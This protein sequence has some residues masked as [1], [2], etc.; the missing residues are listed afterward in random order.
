MPDADQ[1]PEPMLAD[2]RP[3]NPRATGE[4]RTSLQARF[5]A[6]TLCSTFAILV[7]FFAYLEVSQYRAAGGEIDDRIGRMLES[8]SL[9]LA[10]ATTAGDAERML[11]LLAPVLGDPDV[12]SIAVDLADGTR[13]AAHGVPLGEISPDLV[14]RHPIINVVGGHPVRVGWVVAAVSHHRI[15]RELRD[16]LFDH[17]V[18]ALLIF[19]AIVIGIQ[20][21]LQPT[22][23]RPMRRLL[24]AI[25]GWE[26][27]ATPTPVAATRNDEFGRL[28]RAFNEMQRRQLVYQQDLRVARDTAEAADR[29]KTAFLAIMSHELRTPLNAI[30]GFSELLKTIANTGGAARGDYLDAIIDSGHKLLDLV[31]DILDV[32]HAYGGRLTL[33]E[34]PVP[35]RETVDRVIAAIHPEAEEKLPRIE[36]AVP[37]SLPELVADRD[38]VMRAL[39]HLVGNAVRFTPPGGRVTVDAAETRDG[40]CLRVIDTGAGIEPERLAQIQRPFA[41][42]SEDWQHHAAGAGLGLTYARTIARLH[43]GTFAIESAPGAGTRAIMAFPAERLS[44]PLSERKLAAAD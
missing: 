12:Q 8:S 31:N 17:I 35:L 14:R 22:V 24:A 36:N 37:G 23:M 21:S 3:D 13:V 34:Q 20:Q 42:A 18:L 29:T 4:P 25:Q 6:F 19:A 28:I 40:L 32:T 7:A 26:A 2:G 38:R 16:H 30:I 15:N 33:V 5:L 44:Q 43:G 39:T 1:G 9:L 41:Q 10:E 27:G 11:L